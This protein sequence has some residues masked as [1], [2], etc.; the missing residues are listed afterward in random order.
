MKQTIPSSP[1]TALFIL[2]VSWSLFAAASGRA[3]VVKASQWQITADKITRYENPPSVI[4]EGNV[5]LEKTETITRQKK[6]AAGSGWSELLEEE[7]GQPTEKQS[8]ATVTETKTIT[9]I[10]ADWLVYDMDLGTVKARGDLVIDVGPDQLSAE[11]G[12]VDL[13]RE[14]GTFYNATIIRQYKDMHFEGRVIEKTGDLTYH[15]EDGWIVTCKLKKGE[16]PPWSFAA[17]DAEITDNGYAFLKHT[18]FR[19]KGVPVLYAPVMLLP[20]KRTR[21]TGFLFPSISSS[22]RDGFGI[23]TPFFINLSPSS[24]I[25]LYPQYLANRGLMA[26]GELRYILDPTSK[27]MLMA[28]YLHDDLSEPS[29]VSYYEDGNYTHTNKDR[30]WLRGKADQDFGNWISRLDLDIVSDRD[31]LTEFSSGLTG[32]HM[33]QNRFLKTFGRG[34]QN[35][36]EDQRQSSLRLLRSWSNGMALQTEFMGVNDQRLD[37][38]SPTPLWKLPS[39]NFTGLVPFYGT[40][41]DFSWDADYVNFWRK[42]GVG[43]HRIDLFPRLTMAVPLSPYLET[44]V[45][46]GIR[47]TTYLIQDNGDPDWADRNTEN[48]FLVDLGGEIG[49]TMIRKFA[50]NAGSVTAWD[51]TFRPYVSY[52]YVSDANQDDLPQFD[53]VDTIADQSIL[54]YGIDNF[55]SVY[56]ERKGKKYSRKY[57][58][59][60]IKQ[61]Y[62]LRSAESDT[63]LTPVNV[64]IDYYPLPDFRFIYRTD[65]DVYGDGFIYHGLEAY[66]KNSR[67]DI[68][69]ADY[70]YDSINNTNS[71]KADARVNLFH[72]FSAGYRIERSIEDSKT[73]EENFSLIYQPACWSVELASNYTPGNQ[74]FTVMFRLANI[75]NPLGI[76]VPGL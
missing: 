73:V 5:V 26:G 56:G 60:K 41:I 75:G 76:Q 54:Y 46:G 8:A 34:F 18:T 14:T 37:K 57:G 2:F 67:G 9:T 25:T 45:D 59:I 48:R 44:T 40:G 65:M 27:G 51:H 62:D 72:Y 13:N 30:Y 50:I 33:S 23:E 6:P 7:T 64:R 39:V 52:R 36:T 1:I 22:D 24:D 70:R 21:Q 31:Y 35:K 28:N 47:N 29:E 53:R 71:I 49:T 42:E 61:G 43:A 66:Y 19:I 4:A 11:S 20:A 74:K 58:Y 63:P 15:I 68:L 16:T 55:F 17:A 32:F 69:S 3:E 38:S 10:K 12:V